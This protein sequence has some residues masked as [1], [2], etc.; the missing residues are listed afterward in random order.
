MTARVATFTPLPEQLDDDALELLRKTVR[1]APGYVAGFHLHDPQTDKALSI[2]IYEDQ[3]ALG[4]VGAALAARP[5]DRKVG[6]DPDVVEFFKQPRSE[7]NSGA[8][9]GSF[10]S[11]PGSTRSQGP[12]VEREAREHRF[13]ARRNLRTRSRASRQSGLLPRLTG[14]LNTRSAC[15]TGTS[16]S[17]SDGTRTRDLRRDRPAL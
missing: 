11:G 16:D 4:Q 5:A 3:D 12:R 2:T 10:A 7:H 15:F 6:I 9:G 13:L 8:K 1:E 14:P 17:G